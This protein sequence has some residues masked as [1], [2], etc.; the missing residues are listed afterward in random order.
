MG[1][2]DS[3]DSEKMYSAEVP[4]NAA[5]ECWYEDNVQPREPGEQILF[6]GPGTEGKGTESAP[7][8]EITAQYEEDHHRLVP[9]PR[10]QVEQLQPDGMSSCCVVVHKKQRPKVTK[11]N[12]QSRDTA[13][14]V[15]RH[16]RSVA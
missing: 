4:Q 8:D 13:K 9:K 14:R 7:A 2:V 12:K 6:P 10:A 3:C 16:R 11:E 1:A 5:N 15:Q